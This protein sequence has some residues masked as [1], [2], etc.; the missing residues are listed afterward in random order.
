MLSTK[1]IQREIIAN[2]VR[3]GWSSAHDLSCTTEGLAEELG[4]FTKARRH[5]DA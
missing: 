1:S 4:E 2:R 3:R 5:H